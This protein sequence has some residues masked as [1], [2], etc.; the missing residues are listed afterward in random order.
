[1]EKAV[2]I[3]V[4]ISLAVLILVFGGLFFIKNIISSANSNIITASGESKIEVTPDITSVYFL[5]ETKLN[6]AEAAKNKNNEIYNK[7][8]TSLAIQG[9]NKDDVKTEQFSVNEN[10]EWDGEKSTRNGFIAQHNL[11]I[12]LKDPE[13]IGKVIDVVV[14]NNA[15]INYINFELSQE[16]QGFYK[17]EALKLAS[18]DAKKK[19]EAIATGLE[20]ELGELVSVQT[21]DF[22]YRPWP[23]FAEGNVV[24]EKAAIERSAINPSEKD[25]MASVTIQYRLE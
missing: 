3:T 10:W 15:K 20:K 2:K 16:K 14:D 13:N 24:A 7:I 1:M 9:I 12:N 23:I 19:A 25:I 8:I 18:E 5:V 22:N 4:I 17:T 21:S 11:K 6:T